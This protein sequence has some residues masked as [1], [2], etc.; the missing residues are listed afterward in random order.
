MTSRRGH[1]TS[2]LP[3]DQVLT[4][5]VKWDRKRDGDEPFNA[6]DKLVVQNCDPMF[7]VSKLCI[8]G[9]AHSDDTWKGLTGFVDPRTL[10]TALGRLRCG[11]DDFEKLMSGAIGK[12]LFQS[13]SE[14]ALPIALRT[15]LD[16]FSRA[17]RTV[18]PRTKLVKRTARAMIVWHV[19]EKTG[20][21]LDEL[22][23]SILSPALGPYL[24]AVNQ[25]QWR[26][27]NAILIAAV[28]LT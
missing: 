1:I 6:F 24:D 20:H 5:L 13:P 22:V 8:L 28:R 14:R 3:F 19:Q 21:C 18:T 11:A 23:A 25:I 10:K 26:R 27:D 7:L 4:D 9:G 12:A 17:V 15:L 16:R 2:D